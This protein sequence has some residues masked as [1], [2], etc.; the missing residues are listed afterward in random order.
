VASLNADSHALL[1]CQF[2]GNVGLPLAPAKTEVEISINRFRLVLSSVRR[3]ARRTLVGLFIKL[4]LLLLEQPTADR[5]ILQ[6]GQ[7]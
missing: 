2:A 1:F 4:H 3:E 5:D 6:N 7:L